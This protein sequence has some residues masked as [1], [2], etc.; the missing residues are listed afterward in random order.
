[1]GVYRYIILSFVLCGLNSISNGVLLAQDTVDSTTKISTPISNELSSAFVKYKSEY[2]PKEVFFNV[3]KIQ[4]GSSQTK[5]F[6][7]RFNTPENWRT[8]KLADQAQAFTLLPGESISVPL[9]VSAP[10]SSSGGVAY[11]INAE[12]LDD[13][14]LP[15]IAPAYCYVNIP[16]KSEWKMKADERYL[17]VSDHELYKP[18]KIKFQNT[19]N[20]EENIKLNIQ[21][22]SKINLVG[23]NQKNLEL[24][25]TLKAFKDTLVE[26]L[27]K[28]DSDYSDFPS[29]R[30]N[31]VIIT[32]QSDEKSPLKNIT[33]W[34]E[35]VNSKFENQIQEESSP[36]VI[37]GDL[38][39]LLTDDGFI[40]VQAGLMGTIELP[41]DRTFRYYFW[42]G[43]LFNKNTNR[44]AGQ[45]YYQFSR[46]YVSYQHKNLYVRL[47]DIFSGTWNVPFNGRGVSATYQWNKHSFLAAVTKNIFNPL[48]TLGFQDS[49]RLR[50]DLTLHGSLGYRSD[51]V[52]NIQSLI[53]TIGAS[54]RYKT[55]SV[56]ALVSPSYINLNGQGKF[57]YGHILSY[58][59][60]YFG[61]IRTYL[62]NRTVAK[63][64]I[65][66]IG[67]TNTTIGSLQYAI[68]K[69]QNLSFQ[70]NAIQSHPYALSGNLSLIDL[71]TRNNQV[72][73]LIYAKSYQKLTLT[74]GPGYQ[75][76]AY[77]NVQSLQPQFM[78]NNYIAQFG[79]NAR[80]TKLKNAVSANV[81]LAYTAVT[82]YDLVGTAT[83]Q[84]PYFSSS[85]VVNVRADRSGLIFGYYYG[86]PSYNFQR[87]Y[88]NSGQG[89]KSFR[90]NPYIQ[91]S[92][93]RDK[94]HLMVNASYWYQVNDKSNRTNVFSYANYDVGK[95]WS[96]NSNV[97]LY[98]FTRLD[99][100]TGR[101]SFSDVNMNFGFKKV[102]D[103]PQPSK[104]YYDLKVIFFKDLNGN[105]IKD[106]NEVGLQDIL[107][108]IENKKDSLS[109]PS[110]DYFSIQLVS[111]PFGAV[112]CIRLL[113]G[114]YQVSTSELLGTQ[115][116][117]NQL[118]KDFTIHLAENMTFYVPF[119]KSNKVLGKVVVKR[120]EFSS[121]AVVSPGNLKVTATDSLG[122]V[123]SALTNQDGSFI[124]YAPQAGTYRI[125]VNNVF[126]EN[127]VL[128]QNDILVDFNGLKEFT[129]TFVFEEKKRKINF[130]GDIN[131]FDLANR[132]FEVN[133]EQG[134]SS[135][136]AQKADLDKQIDL[137]AASTLPAPIDKSKIRFMVQ[138]GAYNTS[139]ENADIEKIRKVA[140]VK[141]SKTTHGLTRFTLGEFKTM[142]QAEQTREQFI[143]SGVLANSEFVIVIGEYAGRYISAKEAQ[144]LLKD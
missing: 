87:Y 113:E 125:H 52:R 92:F 65:D 77:D 21:L 96:V 28:Y 108:R 101:I 51:Q 117:L 46:M 95:G 136:N 81:S 105:K 83:P 144:E 121:L 78:S 124:L 67:S 6:N 106:E 63:Y 132:N 17:Y 61:K 42:N 82:Q 120:D 56:T 44:T 34:F 138:L 75:Y 11:V 41:R 24:G 1:M 135:N 139:V 26:F 107:T 54:F 33:F 119:T 48:W 58:N 38:F 109:G 10:Q 127:F 69:T 137:D 72:M 16:R 79:L 30:D 134:A 27:A 13:Q 14:G 141:E 62:N 86:A 47:G 99:G 45:N 29:L 39:N 93:L 20:S 2:D 130:K 123:F 4:N 104:K 94:L 70:Y 112:E 57:G 23:F 25:L 143:K 73:S 85:Y 9:R 3:L 49:Y 88:V 142:Q 111:D 50:G 115:E 55:S 22:G 126:G 133:G 74:A 102:F 131:G 116:Y 114:D 43:N 36:L 15:I 76:Y 84:T 31:R 40:T 98:Y 53:P 19:G 32:A 12:L 64:F 18:I 122:N 110:S 68:G 60:F 100:E 80:G 140:S 35:K 128:Y 59:G 129:V 5:V 118:G 91:R 90:I 37:W 71:G 97:L 8:I 89:N 103:L 66:A 7:V